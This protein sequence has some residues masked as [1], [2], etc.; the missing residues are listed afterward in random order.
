MMY[1]VRG[2]F[3]EFNGLKGSLLELY[4][5][6]QWGIVGS[7]KWVAV[8]MGSNSRFPLLCS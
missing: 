3:E 4:G 5:E 8:H 1:S 6:P 2:A 7:L